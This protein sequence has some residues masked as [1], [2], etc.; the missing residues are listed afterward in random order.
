MKTDCAVV[1]A[2]FAGCSAA[3]ELADAGY[4]VDLFIKG[5]LIVDS[6]STLTAGGLTAVSDEAVRSKADSYEAHIHD[7]LEAGK[8]LNDEKIVQFCSEHFYPDVIEWLVRLGVQFDMSNGHYDL[9]REGGHSANRVYHI[10]DETGAHIMMVLALKVKNHPRI[11]VHEHHIAIDLITK[12]KFL[13]M[14]GKDECVGI[15]VFD[16]DKNRVKAVS[17]KSV[18]LATGG[19]GKVFLYTSNPDAASGDGFAMAYRAGLPLVNMEFIQFHPTVFYDEQADNPARRFLFTEALRGEGAFLKIHKDDRKDFVLKY[20]PRGSKATRDIVTRAEDIEM[21]KGG[22]KH[23]WL[24]CTAI[25]EQRLKKDFRTAYEFCLKKGIDMAKEPVP[26]VYAVHYSNGGVQVDGNSETGLNNLYVLG[27]SSYTGLH[28]A[29]RLASNS[30]PECVLFG[31]LSA[32]H[33]IKNKKDNVHHDV[34]DWDTGR[35]KESKDPVAISYYWDITRKTMTL[36]CGIARTEVR[37][38]AAKDVM[39]ALKKNINSDY[40]N[41]VVNKDFLEARNLADV[42]NVV[43]DSASVR[44]ES[45]ACHY[46]ED[47]PQTDDKYFGLTIVRRGQVPEIKAK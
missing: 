18:F 7:T 21:R 40:W 13:K 19:L 5:Q 26:V 42:A 8:G 11:R 44:K 32:L 20:N 33:F 9:H 37:L 3:L 23:V 14:S 45:R 30:A 16:V 15:Y 36:L 2:G 4:Q 29:T 39:L 34:P 22:L 6:A 1:G 38:S 31:R 46:R 35:A 27:E 47:Y 24:D 25:P 17:S 12:N 28:G 41:Y 10:G 43:L